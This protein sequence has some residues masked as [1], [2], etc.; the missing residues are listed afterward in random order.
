MNFMKALSL[1]NIVAPDPMTEFETVSTIFD[2]VETY[3]M[4]WCRTDLSPF[5]ECIKCSKSTAIVTAVEP[6]FCIGIADNPVV[7]TK[8]N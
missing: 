5:T 7:Q 8:R 1:C 2:R 6:F 3:S 4:F